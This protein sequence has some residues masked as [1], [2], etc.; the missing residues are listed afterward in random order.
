[1]TWLRKSVLRWPWLYVALAAVLTLITASLIPRLQFDASI[2]SMIPDDDPVLAELL[3]VTEEFG[4]QELFAVALRAEDVYTPAVL[5]KIHRLAQEIEALPGVSQVDSPLSAQMIESGFF[6]IDIRPVA[7]GVPQSPEE[8]EAFRADFTH[9]PYAGRL[10]TT[11]G[12][13]AM[14]LVKFEPW[15]E[16]E[17]RAVVEEI[18]RIAQRYEGPEE[19]SVVGDLY[20]FHYTEYAMQR[21]LFRLVPFVAIVIIAV[22]YWT[23]RS[24]L[25]VFIPLLTVTISLVWTLGLMALFE[26]P[27]SI[28]SMVLPMIL[29][30][31]GIASG[32]HI[33]NKYQELLGQGLE[34]SAALERTFREITSPVVMAALTTSAGFASLV[35]AFVRPIREFGIFTAFGVAAAMGLSLTLVPAVLSLVNPPP[36][37][38]EK[39]GASKT[40]LGRGLQRVARLALSRGTLVLAV[41]AGLLVVMAVGGSRIQ[42]ESNI[43]NYFDER[44]PIRQATATVEE[45]FGGSMQLAVVFDTGEPDGIKDPEV[46][47][48][49]AK[50]Q[51]YLNSF[52]T[53][54]HPTSIVDVLKLLNQALWDG[55]PSFYTIPESREAV[56]QQL[57]L[58]TMQGGSG[59]DSMVS[60][61]YQQAL[62]NAQM[63]TLDAGE[64]A[65]VIRAVEDYVE[66]EFGG[67]PSLTVTVTGTPKVMMRLMDRYVQ[68]QISSLVTSS[69]GVGLIVVLLMGSAA[70]GLLCLVPLLFTVVVNF[71]AMGFVGVPLDAVTSIIASLAIGLGID[72]AIHYVS[73]YRLEREA[74][75]SFDQAVL[76]AG[77]TS[78]RA[79]FFNSAALIVGFLVLAFSRYFQAIAIFGYLM[80]LTMVI[81]SLATLA[82]IPVLLRFYENRKLERGRRMRRMAVLFVA[83][84]LGISSAAWAVDLSGD[85]ILS[86]IELGN[87][88]A[89]S[90]TAELE[91]ITENPNGAQRSYTLRIYRMQ[92]E[93]GEKQ[94]LEYLAPADVRGTKF[95]SI[96]EGDGPSQMWLYMPALGRERRIA[97]N[98]TGDKF[99]GTDFTYEEIAGD[100]DYEEQYSAAR[101]PD[102]TVDGYGVY[103]LDLEPGADAPYERVKMWVRHEGMLPMRL[104]LFGHGTA[105]PSKTL[106]LGD[107]REVEGEMIPHYLEMR[108][109]LAKTRTI[110]KL[111]EISSEGVAEDIFS[112]RYLRR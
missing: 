97:A 30:T 51:E 107:F 106:Q 9:T 69:V 74:G 90:G 6:G 99:M 67:D 59:L 29:M 5:Q 11:D 35:T 80:A 2:T 32:I 64:L 33:L 84:V 63:K 37:K 110:I 78:G 42:L 24:F 27:I 79:I 21:D 56:A 25:G 60:Y 36:V 105:E 54:N 85:D 71:G 77:T 61:D 18:E 109:E 46:L 102:E 101:L 23:F 40:L 34:K 62:I 19:I 55:D 31:L 72:Y 91:M 86:Q 104:E 83:L 89:G 38:G 22:L 15:G 41:G 8:I 45:V 57:L 94:L 49:I 1:M 103:V 111:S 28:I 16:D 58:F 93:T 108:D 68:T 87:L 20:I 95:L 4:S 98:M 52:S 39:E 14:L 50:T 88:L 17:K 96:K 66:A 100:F 73:R 44:T 26:V 70:L 76:A 13:G 81:S 3:E 47:G 48:R 53:I 112:L 82:I 65:A 10:I 75:K 43:V 92:D 12:R 7:D